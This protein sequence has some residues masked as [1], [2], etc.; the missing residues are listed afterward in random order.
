MSSTRTIV[1][2]GAASGMGKAT[3]QRLRARGDRVIG[4]DLQDVD[5]EVDLGN[6]EGRVQAIESIG[7]LSGGVLDGLVTFAGLGGFPDRAGS[8][9]VSVNYFG[10]V[11]LLDGLRPMLARGSAPAAVAIASNSMTSMPGVPIE[12]TERCLAGDEEGARAAADEANSI[13]SYPA[14]K[15]AVT[16]WVRRQA[17]GP[18]WAGAGISL[19]VIAP[20]VVETPLLQAT[21]DDALL[22][23]LVEAFPVPLG[24]AG[25]ADE[26]AGVVEFLLGPDARFLCGSVLVVDGG[27]EASLRSDDLPMPMG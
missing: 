4:V 19:N 5:V 10:T 23:P 13:M 3:A 21:R 24:R 15:L 16:R 26:L 12:V 20:G 2:T 27:T 22:G 7:E 9:L 14:T 6:L 8:L 18:D 17:P 1:V 11:T 25:T